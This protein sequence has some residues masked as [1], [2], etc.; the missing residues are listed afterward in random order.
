[1]QV[2]VQDSGWKYRAN[3]AVSNQSDETAEV[4]PGIITLDELTPNLRSLLAV[5]PE[6]LAH[7]PNHQVMW[8]LVNAVPSH[9][10]V[11][12]SVSE[13]D[14]LANRQSET[15]D[16]LNPHMAMASTHHVAFERTEQVDLQSIAL[17]SGSVPAG[18]LAAGVMWF[19]RDSVA[20]ELS[21]RVPVGNTVYDFSF[22]LEDKK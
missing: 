4:L 10:A 16:Y 3:V 9:S 20:H 6:K 22:S 21:M 14:R 8:T 12:G 13:N 7:A 2:S 17:K 1:V 18:Q 11:T 15:Q 5:S 19:E